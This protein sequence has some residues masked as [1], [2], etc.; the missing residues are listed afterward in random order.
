MPSGAVSGLFP[1]PLTVTAFTNCD[2]YALP[3]LEFR[4]VIDQFPV[5]RAKLV[6]LSIKCAWA[7][8]GAS[9]MGA[10]VMGCCHCNPNST[11]TLMDR[12]HTPHTLQ[13]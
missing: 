11:C 1:S 2:L 3:A 8:M 6:A 10:S 12:T 9:V 7:C 4:E 13:S 5:F